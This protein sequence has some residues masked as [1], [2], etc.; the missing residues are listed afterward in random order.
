MDETKIIDES[1]ITST[2]IDTKERIRLFMVFQ[3]QRDTERAKVDAELIS[4][5]E[6]VTA[7]LIEIGRGVEKR[8]G[9]TRTILQAI[10][11]G[12]GTAWAEI[13]KI[14]E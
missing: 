4:K 7:Q 11:H 14:W 12:W 2:I 13:K 5:V 8:E 1:L 9:M 10:N 6:K 3:A